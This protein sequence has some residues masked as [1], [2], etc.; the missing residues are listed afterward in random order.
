MIQKLSSL[1]LLGSISLFFSHSLMAEEGAAT[2]KFKVAY[3][4][5][6]NID[7]DINDVVKEYR[8]AK[9]DDR[10]ALAAKFEELVA[11]QRKLMA[12]LRPLSEAAYI[13]SPNTND[14]VLKTMIGLIAFDLQRDDYSAATK[15]IELM[16]KN[17]CKEDVLHNFAGV[18][19]YC[20]HD[21][22]K[23]EEHLKKA[24]EAGSLDPQSSSYLAAIK[25]TQAGWKKELAVREKESKDDNLPRVKMTTSKGEI[26]IELFENEAPQAVGNFVSL[27]EKEYYD[28][29]VFHRVLAGFMAQG[30]CPEGTGTGG[31]GYNIFCECDKENYRKHYSGTLSMA[32]AGKNTGGSQFFLT[33]RP[34]PHLDGRHT[35]FGRVIKG[36][37]VLPKL[38]RIDPSRGG[39]PA[40]D[41]IVKM[42]VVRKRD[43]E[44]KPTKVE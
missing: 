27:I 3:N 10:K 6:E 43:H 30:G 21:F 14:D 36:M 16:L 40:P 4:K 44:Y 37:D 13:E 39:G 5:F 12:S 8:A 19:A 33:F 34:T 15:F 31:P 1:L 24:K 11:E 29:L 25:D 32:H 26:I 42:E 7:K 35:A 2:E 22:D 20:Q 28:G 38:Q 23:A 18:V 17:E 9:P 41:K